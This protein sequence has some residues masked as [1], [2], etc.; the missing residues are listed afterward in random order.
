MVSGDRRSSIDTE[1]L[2][3]QRP[4]GC[5]AIDGIDDLHY[6][7]DTGQFANPVG[8]RQHPVGP[9]RT[10]VAKSFG[11]RPEH[12]V[13]EIDVPRVRRD[14]RTFHVTHITQVALIDDV[15]EDRLRYRVQLARLRL[16]D[17]IEQGRK[18]IAEVETASAPVTNIEHAFEFRLQ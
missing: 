9:A 1:R 7:R 4:A 14:V 3:E 8:I 17:C 15:P 18:R 16:V 11:F 13:G 5:A 10:V 2:L 12:Q 6:H